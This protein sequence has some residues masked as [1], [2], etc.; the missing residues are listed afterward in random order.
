MAT[1]TERRQQ[2]LSDRRGAFVV[3]SEK[4]GLIEVPALSQNE[5]VK[6]R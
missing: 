5:A 4:C 1:D 3:W 6:D 2:W